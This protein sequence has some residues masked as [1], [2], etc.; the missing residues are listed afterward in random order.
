MLKRV[1]RRERPERPEGRGGA[2]YSYFRKGEGGR[3]TA[4]FELRIV[5]TAHG[6]ARG[7]GGGEIYAA[8]GRWGVLA[9]GGLCQ[10]P[11]LA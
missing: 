8:Y 11:G 4:T 6:G 7:G 1:K 10:A 5:P 3:S 9:A 2:Y